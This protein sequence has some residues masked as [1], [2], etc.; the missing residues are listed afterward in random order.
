MITYDNFWITLKEKGESWYS[1]TKRYHISDNLLHRLKH[2]LPIN[3][4]TL[5]RLCEI[6]DCG[7]TDILTYQRDFTSSDKNILQKKENRRN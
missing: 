3:T 7:P 2:N 6:L 5:D 4:A 1:L